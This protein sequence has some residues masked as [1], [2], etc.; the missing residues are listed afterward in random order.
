MLR[1][2]LSRLQWVALLI[3]FIGV[4]CVQLQ[5]H[6]SKV[7]RVVTTEQK[8]LIGLIAVI[9]SCVMSGFAGVYFEKILKGTKQ[10]I[11]LRNVQLGA[12]GVV[13]GLVAMDINDGVQVHEK[14][15]FY[16]YDWIVWLVIFI[17]AFGG[18]MVAVVVKYADN[19]LKGFATSGAII[20]S[21]IASRYFF[22][23]QFSPQFLSGAALV[24]A[25]VFLYSK[26]APQPPISPP[27]IK[28]TPPV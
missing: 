2:Q 23:F 27:G 11:W 25:S 22:D 20:L 8:P 19:I 26:F 3:L 14:G 1:K 16:G 24:I 6:D 17:Q 13:F 15:F 5:P 7:N 10:S 4:S 9:V 21:C 28:G 18:L 12:I